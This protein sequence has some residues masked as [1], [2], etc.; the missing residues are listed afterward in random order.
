[1]RERPGLIYVVYELDDADRACIAAGGR[2]MLGIHTEPIPPISM[3]T[4]DEE[5][6][7]PISAH[8][9]KAIPELEDPER[10]F[11]CECRER[12]GPDEDGTFPA[13]AMC[14]RAARCAAV[15]KGNE[16]GGDA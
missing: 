13:I 11:V 9:W 1:M 2:I 12:Y 6:Y 3:Q 14:P 8:P 7:R 16:A 10:A 15:L 5:R 4:I